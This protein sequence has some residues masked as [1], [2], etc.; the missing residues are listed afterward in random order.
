MFTLK[1]I[2]KLIPPFV[3]IFQFGQFRSALTDVSPSL[4]DDARA[5]INAI[6]SMNMT[7]HMTAYR[8]F[9][10]FL[11]DVGWVMDKYNELFRGK[12]DQA[13]IYKD[14]TF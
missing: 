4:E 5:I 6:D 2:L 8:S 11:T 14:S 1:Q 7:E 13:I 3:I 12:N 10:E 9:G